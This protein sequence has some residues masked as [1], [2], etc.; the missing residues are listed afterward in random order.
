MKMIYLA[1]GSNLNKDQMS[2]RCPDA[3]P[4]GKFFLPNWRLVF[5]GVA[6]IEKAEGFQV[7]VGAWELTDRCEKALDRYEGYP[8]L[9]GKQYFRDGK[10]RFMSY[11]MN[12]SGYSR[13]PQQ[14]YFSIMQGYND[15]GLPKDYLDKAV[16]HSL[17]N[18]NS[19]GHIPRRF[20]NTELVSINDILSP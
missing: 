2:I 7:P 9:Y 1:Y 3:K 12:R 13:P 10:K 20:R 5:K 18:D 16:E 15:F 8:T 17:Q 4:L 6:D 11:T 14:Y 19:E